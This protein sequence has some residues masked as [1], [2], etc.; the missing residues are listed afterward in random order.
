MIWLVFMERD[1]AL[2]VLEVCLGIDPTNYGRVLDRGCCSSCLTASS[3]GGAQI[4][5]FW[6]VALIQLAALS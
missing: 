6:H 2:H 4:K 1:G 3:S 5:I